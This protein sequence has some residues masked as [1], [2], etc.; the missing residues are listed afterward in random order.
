MLPETKKNTWHDRPVFPAIPGFTIEIL[1]VVIILALAAV[2]R[3]YN[4]GARVMSHDEVN[5]VVPSYDYSQGRVYRYDPVTH[6][7][8]QFHLI[9][10][11]YFLL[12]DSDFSSRVPVVLFGIAT[13]AVVLLAFRRYL[14]RSGALVAGLLFLISPF[15]LF[16]S[17]YARNEIFIVLWAVL[18][19]YAILR[20]LE[21]GQNRYLYLFALVNALHFIDKAT[22]YIFAAE[23]LIFLVLFFV[24]RVSRRKW[25]DPTY[26]RNF[27]LLLLLAMLMAGAALGV[28][29]TSK[30]SA[31]PPTPLAEGGAVQPTQAPLSTAN[32]AGR[33][34]LP[35]ALSLAVISGLAALYFLVKG[36]GWNGI[37]D[38]RSF[39]LFVLQF[40]LVLPLLGALPIKLAGFDP[41]DYAFTGVIRA[42]AFII[43]LAI[44]AILLGWWWGRGVWLRCAAIF[45]VLFTVFYTS[46]FNNGAGFATGLVGALGYWMAQ[47][48]V[49]RGSQ[50]WYYYAAVQ[51]PMYEYLAVLGT[52]LAIYLG[53]R[54]RLWMSRPWLPFQRNEEKKEIPG[55]NDQLTDAAEV[56]A[57]AP[58]AEVVQDTP[59]ET[60]EPVSQA[61]GQPELRPV[62]VL[63]LL[64]FWSFSSLLAF[65]IAGEKM[66]WLAIHIAAPML[67]ASGWG[68]GY[69]IDSTRWDR[70][71][72]NR[73]WLVVVLLVLLFTSLA[74]LL[75]S[76]LGTQPPF[77]GREL[78]QLEAS[79]TFVMSLIMVLA[80]GYGLLRLLWEWRPA[81][82]RRVIA[83]T[84]FVLLAVL[85]ARAAFRAAYI[86]Y[87]T[88][89]EFLVYAH[90]ARGHKDALA[91]IEEISYRTTM[92]KDL[93]IAYD[94]DM[95]YPYWWYLRDYHNNKY[96]ADKPTRD[97]RNAVVIVAGEAAFA[98]VDA[99]AGEAYYKFDYMRLWWPMQDYWNLT[100]ERILNAVTD[101]KIRA[102]IF[103]I[104]L[105]AD[106]RAYA[107]ATNSTSLSLESWQP[108][109]RMRLYIRKDVVSQMWSYGAAPITQPV[110][111]DPYATGR[112]QLSADQEI[113]APEQLQSP[114]QLAFAKGGSLYV[115]DST[116]NRILHFSPDGQLLHSWGSFADIA[117]GD[118][119]GGT[120]NQIWGVAVGPDGS[121]Y[122][123]DWWN[124]RIQKFT[125]DG[126]FITMWGHLGDGTTPDAFYGPR[127]L[128]VD[129]SGRVYVADT[130]NKRIVVF[131]QDG[132]YITKFGE[133]GSDPGQFDEPSAVA[134]DKDGQVY[135][136]DTWNQRVQVFKP[137]ATGTFFSPV[138]EWNIEGWYGQSVENKPYIAVDD[139]HVFVTDPEA[140]RVLEFTLKGEFVHVWGDYGTDLNGI[141]L[142]SGIAIDP[143]GGV[144]V[145][146]TANQRLL[147]FI[148]P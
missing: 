135:V 81:E 130:G 54:N 123:S 124:H 144:W 51:L 129:A 27:I 141:G 30:A 39:D 147:R 23:V 66:A 84:F 62:P 73:G 108:S 32:L 93:V 45:W 77:Q 20:Y 104:W 24:E 100:W 70:L 69:L 101:P 10:L 121:V 2:S 21:T 111:V 15:M 82:V 40:T 116:N 42:L 128:A 133:V 143:Q 35:L 138:L 16:Y 126:Q 74:G 112:I 96:F 146:D 98:K 122:V 132:N 58:Q 102:G 56:E 5:H 145:S 76:L 49:N 61:E 107:E 4:V 26:L 99:I 119:P 28:S 22:S 142:A 6:G 9:A 103:N 78:V 80:S 117:T 113:K 11:S 64:I 1:L 90:A 33:I 72:A 53:W 89:K 3:F 127:G 57:G 8:L 95:L 36:L 120:F 139:Q 29:V 118:A 52:L 17:R 50:P 148:V 34:A 140:Y 13:I 59:T 86:N 14:G 60:P 83:L 48:A 47:Q 105:N 68:L 91:Q 106:Y 19:L 110:T 87:D 134:I 79:A 114:R 85:T 67:L 71:R 43:P 55:T 18:I 12:G 44:I 136:T 75:G 46:F 31:L 63:A 131:D 97:I 41:L 65:S 137:D 92:G 37:R 38:E 94:N 125:A 109:N 115:G 88:A 7:P 25:A